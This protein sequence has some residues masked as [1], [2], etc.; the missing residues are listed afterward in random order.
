MGF[1]C[2][3]CLFWVVVYLL[4]GVFCCCGSGGFLFVF[5][6]FLGQSG[7]SSGLYN[8]LFLYSVGLFLL[9]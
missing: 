2:V 8:F 1:C 9:R 7:V 4:F 3:F 5:S 6:R